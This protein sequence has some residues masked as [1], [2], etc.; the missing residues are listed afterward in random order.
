VALDLKKIKAKKKEVR[1][2]DPIEI[3]QGSSVSDPSI[4]DLWLAQGDALRE[5]HEKRASNDVGVILNTGAGKTLVGLLIAKS[6]VNETRGRVLYAC[7]S[8][9]LVEQTVNKAKG[10]GLPVTSYYRKTFSNDLFQRGEAPCITTY[11]ALL[12]GHSKFFRDRVDAV[13]FDDAHAA[14]HLLRDHFSLQIKSAVRPGVYSA[15][16]ALFKEYHQQIGMTGSYEELEAG[17]SS[18]LFFVPPFELHRQYHELM[19]VLGEAN[20]GQDSDATYAWEHLKDHIDLCCLIIS[21]NAI[22][23]TPPYVPCSVLPYFDSEVRRIYLSATL[24]APDAFARTYGRVPDSIIAPVTS[25]GECERLI[26]YPSRLENGQEDVEIAKTLLADKKTLVMVPTYGRANKWGGF[27][28]P[29]E[30]DHVSAQVE[31]FKLQGGTP[32]LLL[33]ARY[34]G[35]DLPGDTCRVMIIDDLP[36]GVGPLERY[37]WEYLDLSNTFRSTIA[38][39]VVQSFGRISRGMSDHGVVFITGERLVDWLLTPRNTELLP[40]FLQKQLEL[41]FEISDRS[42]S[43]DDYISVIDQSLSRE[44]EWLDAYRDYMDEADYYEADEE[45]SSIALKLANSEAAFAEFFWSRDY[46]NA[47]KCLSATL[48]DAFSFS[49]STGAWHSLWLGRSFQLMGDNA[50]ANEMYLNAHSVKRNIPPIPTRIDIEGRSEHSPQII[51]VDR[52]FLSKADGTII[53]PKKLHADLA[54]LDGSG[55]SGQTEESLRALGQ[56]LGLES[57]RPDNEF[58]TGPDVLWYSPGLPALCI[59]VKTNKQAESL[60]K[61]TEVGQ[62]G[63]HVQWVI[64]HTD[65]HEIIPVFVGPVNGATDTANPPNDFRVAPLDHFHQVAEVLVAALTDIA[66]NA[67][68][69]TLRNTIEELFQQRKIEWPQFLD[70]I[71]FY[72]LKDL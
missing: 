45:N 72:K 70:H 42:E 1:P 21:N 23:I 37:L 16:L 11:Q 10:Y 64:D 28:V 25:A 55:T 47:A 32:K 61:K 34:D 56:Y 15:I 39:R 36:M 24:S 31:A 13:I 63:D 12:N 2:V 44:Q 67:L 43:L 17:S 52:L 46:P 35:M 29:P 4:N 9:Q 19:R 53:M 3:F 30:R 8:I 26:V 5:W 58:G 71:Q 6:L 14:E 57:S 49:A 18:R 66:S 50:S 27:A 7:S 38:S 20:L 41:G 65:T 69:L 40:P 59:E 60:Y 51:N 22:T 62:L 54:Y 33:A 68:P 48:E